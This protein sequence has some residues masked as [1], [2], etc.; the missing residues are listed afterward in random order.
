MKGLPMFT[1]SAPE[2][3]AKEKADLAE[4]KGKGLLVRWKGYFG[5]TGPG[6]L[7]SA[8]VLGSGSAMASL[9]ADAYY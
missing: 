2:V 1:A 7:Q 6:W 4:L 8:L 5:K 9:F 3:L